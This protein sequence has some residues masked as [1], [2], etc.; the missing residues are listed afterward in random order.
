MN[1]PQGWRTGYKTSYGS[2]TLGVT[3]H[4]SPLTWMRPEL[5]L[6][7]NFAKGVD[8]Y[9]NLESGSSYVGT[10][11]YQTTLGIDLIQWF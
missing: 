1:D 6:E 11:N 3:H 9:D 7:K 8:A 4:F 2:L 5:R 10:K